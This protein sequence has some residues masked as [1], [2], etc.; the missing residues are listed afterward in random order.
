M[1]YSNN[2]HKL[3]MRLCITNN[4]FFLRRADSL[5]RV[6]LLFYYIHLE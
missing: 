2:K 5:Y 6:Y 3:F 1:M 4:N